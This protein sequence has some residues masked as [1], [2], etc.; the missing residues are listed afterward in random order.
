[1]T[2]CCRKLLSAS[3]EGGRFAGLVYAHQLNI[4][5][6]RSIEDL[7]LLANVYGPE[8]MADRIVYLP[9]R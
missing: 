1:M 7:E 3:G 5:I 6:R 4:T 2:T 8:D 9:L